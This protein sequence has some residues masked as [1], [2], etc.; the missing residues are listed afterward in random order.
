[1]SLLRAITYSRPFGWVVLWPALWLGVFWFKRTKWTP[2]LSYWAMRRLYC[3]TRGRSNQWIK[4]RL[5][6]PAEK[7]SCSAT[8]L[9][10][11][12]SPAEREAAV[13]TLRRE[14]FVVL[15]NYLTE[16]QITSL[17]AFAQQVPA[18]LTPVPTEGPAIDR[19][20]PERPRAIKYDLPE[21]RL[22]EHPVVQQLLADR[23]LRDLARQFLD[24][25][26]VNDLVA[27]WWSAAYSSEASS[28]A[29]QLYH[30]D[31]DRPQFLK[32][33]FYLTDVTPETG[34]HCYIRGSHRERAPALWRDGRHTDD[35]VLAYYGA[36][37]EVQITGP[38][39]TLIAVD[40]SGFHKGKP[41]A[42][43]YRLILQIEYTSTLFGQKYNRIKVQPTAFWHAE[44]AAS[45][46]FMTR[47][48]VF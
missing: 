36:E 1:M 41:L 26:P 4:K 45:P 47:F 19:F 46:V 23:S 15:G 17:I 42:R 31:M 30:F 48:S 37:R 44:I 5:A 12:M 6:A 14:G 16:A 35:Q 11:G 25:E 8:G 27:M 29:A 43:G 20:D 33:F 3:I 21:G 2:W 39:G 24:C 13:D 7:G 38:R 10:A 34:P 22:V 9:L 28:E 18:R 32:L 40:T